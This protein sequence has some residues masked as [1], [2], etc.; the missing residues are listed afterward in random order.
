M[1]NGNLW[2]EIFSCA[3]TRFANFQ[4]KRNN[5]KNSRQKRCLSSM[6]W[7]CYSVY[8]EMSRQKLRLV[9]L[10]FHWWT[11]EWQRH[12][13]QLQLNEKSG[14]NYSIWTCQKL[15]CKFFSVIFTSLSLSLSMNTQRRQ[16]SHSSEMHS[17]MLYHLCSRTA[18]K[19]V[20][21]FLFGCVR[22]WVFCLTSL[23]WL[24]MAFDQ[25]RKRL[26]IKF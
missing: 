3:V 12:F 6:N 18:I 26:I 8:N 23:E 16:F 17:F 7:R 10:S 2:F 4:R 20:A 5:E 9:N 24:A 11:I 1:W 25:M 19:K 13:S 22:V 15:L 14:P 21:S